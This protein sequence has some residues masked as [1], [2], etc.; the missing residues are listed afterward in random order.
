VLDDGDWSF[1]VGTVLMKDFAVQGQLIET[2]LFMRHS[3]GGWAGYSYVW[4]DA[5]TDATLLASDATRVVAGQTWHYPSRSQC[6][7]CHTAIAGGSLGPTT[8]QMNRTFLYPA[9]GR[10]ANQLTTLQAI[11]MFTTPLPAPASQLPVLP[12]PN[13]PDQP[14]SLRARGYL[15][16]NCAH[17][18]APGGPTEASM[19]LRYAAAD[20]DMNVCGV[21][22][23]LSDLGIAGAL[24]LAPGD[25][26]HSILSRRMHAL[27]DDRMPPLATFI[28]D[29]VGTQVI[30]DWITSVMSCSGPT[31]STTTTTTTRTS[32]SS[33]TSTTTTTAP[34]STTNPGTQMSFR[35]IAAEDGDVTESSASSGVGGFIMAT[36]PNLQ[37]GDD[38]TNA[39]TKGI[40][41]FDTSLIPDDATIVSA[42]LRLQRVG[43]WGTNPFTILGR[44]F[45][46]VQ[47]GGFGGDPA[48]QLSDFQA[49]AT[50]VAAG[51]LSSATAN[52]AWSTGTLNAAGLAAINKTGTTQFR[53]VFEVHDNGNGV[54]DRILYGSG[55]AADPTLRPELQVAYVQ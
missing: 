15:Q 30:D 16:A 27:D 43:V 40:V 35:S 7:S 6:L 28:V 21:P 37:V 12:G 25:P 4:D 44:C 26:Q 22:P 36:Q 24:L 13:T 50:V 5:L 8:P 41:S 39:Q 1:P 9:T 54:V 11:G 18:H 34:T 20:G 10:S 53:L 42:T 29:P 48:L 45:I 33:T 17:C 14:L 51:T 55:E 52:K 3:D 46:E 38:R 47:T 31:T 2:R 23:S 19:D 49:P 32:T